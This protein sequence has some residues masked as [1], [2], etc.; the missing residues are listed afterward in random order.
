MPL[1]LKQAIVRGG[2]PRCG[3]TVVLRWSKTSTYPHG[4]NVGFSHAKC[5]QCDE[6]WYVGNYADCPVEEMGTP[7]QALVHMQRMCSWTTM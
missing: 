3:G 4:P 6:K 7:L 2:C 1:D 5:Q